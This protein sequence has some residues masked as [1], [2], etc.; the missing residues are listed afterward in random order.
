MRRVAP[1]AFF[2]IVA[3]AAATVGARFVPGP[4]YE[5][6]EK[7]ALNPPNWIFAPVWTVLYACMGVAAALAWN[8]SRSVAVVAPWF[9]QLALNAA[10]SWLFFGLHRPALAFVDISVLWLAIAATLAVFWTRSRVAGALLVPYLAW[11]SFAAWLNF[12]LWRL[13]A[14]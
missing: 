2:L 6:L 10:W 14:A 9:A 13:N 12:Q 5:A 7:P 11:V 4:W 8:A 3:F 1:F